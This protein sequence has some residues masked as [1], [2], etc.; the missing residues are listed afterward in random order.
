MAE[1]NKHTTLSQLPNE[2]INNAFALRS[3]KL[4]NLQSLLL[5]KQETT[6]AC[7]A[8]NPERKAITFTFHDKTHNIPT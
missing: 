5:C 3:P 4:E 1:R 7:H 8:A 2:A 6:F